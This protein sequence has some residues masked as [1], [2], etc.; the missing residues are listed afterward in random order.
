MVLETA[1]VEIE[2]L[3]KET[4]DRDKIIIIITSN[5][6]LFRSATQISCFDF[7]KSDNHA[8]KI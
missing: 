1:A 6:F 2:Q 3:K 5:I 4:C 8:N 7:S